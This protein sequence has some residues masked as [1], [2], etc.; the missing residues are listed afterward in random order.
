VPRRWIALFAAGASAA[1]LATQ[2]VSA[3]TSTARYAVALTGS[4][5]SVVTKT[6]TTTDDS[7][8]RIRHADRDVQTVTFASRS[9]RRLAVT[10]RLPTM[11]FGLEAAVSG[12]FHR[13]TTSVGPGDRCISP[14]RKSNRSCAPARLRAR[15][16]ARSAPS[17]IVRL[18]GGFLRARDRRRCA[19]TLTSA[20]WF[21]IPT[22]SRLHRSPA[23]ATRIVVI[24]RVVERTQSEGGV[25][26]TTTI[27]WRL[28]LRRV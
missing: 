19:T 12:S 27:V 5:L 1:A 25:T 9:R 20:D 16:V 3:R 11:R 26:K 15:L 14:P 24:G 2:A 17:R 7:G 6:G 8:C 22:E 10:S 13:E 18:T 21:I 28:V 23:G 4:Q